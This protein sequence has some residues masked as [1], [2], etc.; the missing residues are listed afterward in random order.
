MKHLINRPNTESVWLY[1]KNPQAKYSDFYN[2]SNPVNAERL[3]LMKL[4][5]LK[6]AKVN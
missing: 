1:E 2:G 4:L 5:Q 3:L 6:N